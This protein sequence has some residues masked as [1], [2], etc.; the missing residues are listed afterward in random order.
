MT[1]QF[2]R[3][4]DKTFKC[5]QCKEHKPESE[6]G[7]EWPYL[8]VILCRDCYHNPTGKYAELKRKSLAPP[9]DFD[10]PDE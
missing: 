7:C 2:H 3:W 4:V 1:L 10:Y 8:G 9:D 5:S 6:F